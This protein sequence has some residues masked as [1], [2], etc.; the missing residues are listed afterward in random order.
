[1]DEPAFQAALKQLL[2]G[3]IQSSKSQVG[4]DGFNASPPAGQDGGSHFGAGSIYF[5]HSKYGASPHF[6]HMYARI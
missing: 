1:M 4:S 6:L 5:I 3:S 2:Q